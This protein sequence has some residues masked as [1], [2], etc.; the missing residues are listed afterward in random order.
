MDFRVVKKT[1]PLS[2]LAF[3]MRAMGFYPSEQQVSHNYSKVLVLM[4]RNHLKLF[5]IEGCF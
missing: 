4:I 5:R 2:E 3:M 1:I